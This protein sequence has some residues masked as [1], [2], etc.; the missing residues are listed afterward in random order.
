M[1]KVTGVAARVIGVGAAALWAI[2]LVAGVATDEGLDS[3]ALAESIGIALFGVANITGVSVIFIRERLAAPWLLITGVAFCIFAIITAGRNQ[4]LAAAVSG[5]PF[6]ASALL[7][8]LS[9][10]FEH[11]RGHRPDAVQSDGADISG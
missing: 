3:E 5:G 11:H 10:R 4:L 9:R 1:A 7:L 8:Y 6:I 2:P